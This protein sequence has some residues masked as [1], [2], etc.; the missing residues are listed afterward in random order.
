MSKHK[1]TNPSTLPEKRIHPKI[2]SK[3]HPRNLHRERYDFE[4]LITACPE[5]SPY[6]QVNAF[7][8]FSIDFA[9][10]TAVKLLNRALLKQYYNVENWD[11]PANYLCPPIPGRADY[12]H[13]VADLL[14]LANKGE[15]PLGKSIRCLDIGVGA[16]CVYPIIGAHSYGW[17]FVGTDI[18]PVAIAAAKKTIDAS[19]HLTDLVECRLQP[20]PKLIFGGM[21]KRDE[22]FDVVIC[23][24]PFHTSAEAAKVETLRKVNNLEQSKGKGIKPFSKSATIAGEIKRIEDVTLFKKKI[25]QPILNFGGTHGELWCKGGEAGFADDMIRQSQQIPK[26]SKWFTILISK[27]ANLKN[28]YATLDRSD[29]KVKTMEMGQGNKVSRVIAW[30]FI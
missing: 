14:S 1:N 24:P 27:Q 19:P 29:A 20:N 9:D 5:L 22:V 10:P 12:I 2:K 28:I 3:L 4:L 6:V 16:N 17:S 8:D 23:N 18:D 21:L 26:S 30:S 13:Y 15:V 7:D 25:T 11:I